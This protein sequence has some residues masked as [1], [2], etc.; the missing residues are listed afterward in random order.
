M[1]GDLIWSYVR[2]LVGGTVSHPLSQQTLAI[3]RKEFFERMHVLGGVEGGLVGVFFLVLVGN[4]KGI[5]RKKKEFKDVRK[6]FNFDDNGVGWTHRYGLD[7]IIVGWF[8]EI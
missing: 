6:F 3:S 2:S 7:A 4:L 8:G 5:V 1:Q